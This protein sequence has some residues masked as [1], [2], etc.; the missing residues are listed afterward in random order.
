MKRRDFI[1]IGAPL[2]LT[3]LFLNGLPL[4]AF[5]TPDLLSAFCEEVDER[6]TV[7]VHL[8]GA[9]DGINNMVPVAQYDE[10]ANVRPTIHLPQNSLLTL[11]SSLSD[12]AQLGVHPALTA[13]KN[14]YDNDELAIIQGV[15]YPLPNRSHFKSQELWFKGGDGQAENFNLDD[16]WIA[17]YFNYRYPQYSGGPFLQNPDPLGIILGN[18]IE[19]GFHSQEEH[20]LYLRLTSGD[21]TSYYTQLANL[22]A[23]P[24]AGAENTDQGSVISHI[25][26][27]ESST[28]LYA[29]RIVETFNAGANGSATYPNTSLAGQLRTVARMISGGI[30]TKVFQCNMGGWDTH[31]NQVDSSNP[32]IG[33]HANL[34][35]DFSNSIAAFQQDLKELGH[36]H[37]VITIVFSEFGRK[38][39]E[40]ANYGTDHGTHNFMYII[41]TPVKSGVIGNGIDLSNRDNQGAPH[42]SQLQYDYRQV[43]G[44][45]LQDWMGAPDEA[46]NEVKFGTQTIGNKL[47]LIE[48]NAVV[49]P[50]CYTF[51]VIVEPPSVRLFTYLEGFY[52]TTSGT[53]HQKLVTEKRTPQKQPYFRSPWQYNG[54]EEFEAQFPDDFV[55]WVLVELRSAADIGTIVQQQ[56]AY[57]ATNGAIKNINQEDFIQFAGLPQ[58]Q[59]Y[60]AVHHRNHLP[61]VSKVP[62]DVLVENPVNFTFSDSSTNGTETMKLMSNGIWV[63]IGGDVNKD[64]QI[65]DND[66][67]KW[68]R[69]RAMVGGYRYQDTDG[70]AVINVGDHNMIK[71][72]LG[73]TS[74]FNQ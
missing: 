7:I 37:K 49:A 63:Q 68:F 28:S 14:L 55:D 65:A 71:Q 4:R 69:K 73:K 13:F 51:P 11:D 67:N 31:G 10:Y 5:A 44:S 53:M 32:L 30:R 66:M 23:I 2:S 6:I 25:L 48:P 8:N 27:V 35:G 42:P 50:D 74:F 43:F 64:G 16:G 47:P 57:V 19:T 12:A 29:N 70:N 40:N 24:L 38:I 41:G 61:V 58:G 26:S 45:L 18:H 3:P 15:G 52:N 34:M 1:R 54:I 17:R 72:N 22:T 46:L 39:I 9:N 60:L 33:R 21:P 36:D 20:E 56:A 59:Y 62:V